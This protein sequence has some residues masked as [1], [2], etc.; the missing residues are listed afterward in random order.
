MNEQNGVNSQRNSMATPKTLVAELCSRRDFI[1]LGTA[2]PTQSQVG[3]TFFDL[4]PRLADITFQGKGY[5]PANGFTYTI[6]GQ[7]SYDGE[8]WEDFAS[9]LLVVA[10]ANVSKTVISTPNT[11]RTNFGRYIRFLVQVNDNNN[12]VATA[13]LS[14]TVAFHFL[15]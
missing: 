14:I 3:A 1:T 15:S 13:Q 10:S 4:G 7:Y 11:V 5:N 9:A 8:E 6:L 12:G 2:T